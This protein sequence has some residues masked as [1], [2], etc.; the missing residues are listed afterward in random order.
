MGPLEGKKLLD[1]GA[2]LGESS[3]YFALQG[4]RVTVVDISP[5]MVAT[6]LAL[7]TKFGVQLEGIVSCAEDLNLP[8]KNLRHHLRRQHDSPSSQPRFLFEQM[9]RA[10]KAGRDVLL[11]V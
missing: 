6:A 3:V 9:S 11:G 7:G 1:L 8:A 10:L 2:G 4:A 5:Q